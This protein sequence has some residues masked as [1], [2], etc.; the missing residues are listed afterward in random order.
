L[1]LLVDDT[2]PKQ[3]HGLLRDVLSGRELSFSDTQGL[4]DI[5]HTQICV[6]A[7]SLDGKH[8]N[9]SPRRKA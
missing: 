5:L 8:S 4:V 3:I 1:R 6:S 2:E 9:Q 7:G